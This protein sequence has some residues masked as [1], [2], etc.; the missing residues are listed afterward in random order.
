MAEEDKN[1]NELYTD[2]DKWIVS[3]MSGILFLLIAS[4]FLYSSVN[5]IFSQIGIITAKGGC[6]NVT[7]LILHSIVFVFI[8]R[9]LMK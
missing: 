8:V 3:I 1:C 6:P 5:S 4:P 9:L 2:K 7:G